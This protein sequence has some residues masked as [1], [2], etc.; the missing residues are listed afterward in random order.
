MNKIIL[1]ALPVICLLS[2]CSN[3][4]TTGVINKPVNLRCEYLAEPLGIDTQ[5]PRLSWELTSEKRNQYQTAY[6]VLV[7]D[8]PEDLSGDKGIMWNSGRVRSGD[9][10]QVSYAGKPLQPCTKYFWK[11]RAWDSDCRPSPYS[12]PASFET[13]IDSAEWQASWIWDGREAPETEAEMYL[14]IPVPLFRK[15]FMVN[16]EIRS[17]RLYISGL[18]Y[19]EAYLNGRK[20][21]KICSTRAGQTMQRGYSI[22]P[23]ISPG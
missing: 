21:E 15:E 11:V 4:A 22:L 12:E 23:M 16:K 5:S 9:N 19:Y 2:S 18:G 20:V 10:I 7:S 14:D 8:N 3:S 6:Q 17:A 13:A 1:A